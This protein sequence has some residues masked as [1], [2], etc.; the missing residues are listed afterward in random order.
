VD[1][2]FV[3][4]NVGDTQTVAAAV[5]DQ[6]NDE[7]SGVQVNWSSSNPA[8]A[9]VDSTRKITAVAASTAVVAAAFGGLNADVNVTMS[10]DELPPTITDDADGEWHNTVQILHLSA[11]DDM[12]GIAKTMYLVNSGEWLEGDTVFI[13][14]QGIQEY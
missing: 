13:V 5:Y 1:P 7:M 10:Q 6:Y 4:L 3:T 2:A 8:V 9:T 11:V 12:S 14:D